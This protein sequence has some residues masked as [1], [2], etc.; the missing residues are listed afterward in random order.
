MRE[1]KAS[2]YAGLPAVKSFDDLADRR[3]YTPLPDDWFVG[4]ADIVGST[5][6]IANGAYKTVNMVGAAV[7]SAQVNAVA[8]APFPFVFGG[9]GAAFANGPENRDGA[10]EALART[11]RWALTE[12]NIDLRAAVV[13]VADIRAAG[14]DVRVAR[15]RTAAGAEYAMFEGGG[16]AWAEERMK[17]G[18]YAVPIAEAG[19]VPNLNGLSCR[20]TPTRA[21]NGTILSVV[22][23][24]AG[25]GATKTFAE[26]IH[27]V[28]ALTGRLDRNGHPL[29]E[30]GAAVHWPPPGL[31]LEAHASHGREPLARRK[32][33]LLWETLIAWL[34]FKTGIKVGGF[35]PA[36]Y[37]RVIDS[38]ADF[39]KFDDGLK[40]TLD[41]DDATRRKL[42]ALLEDAH[43][44]GVAVYGLHAQDQALM[45]CFVPSIHRDD[46]VHFI[47]G[48]DGGYTSAAVAMKARSR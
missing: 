48:A 1:S 28:L 15:H 10:A 40:M 47:D 11:K 13:P 24:P 2:F 18:R 37:K 34:V 4:A 22:I 46:H 33:Q 20:W 30:H 39:R 23:Q 29:P 9:D 45:T 32:R 6:A 14:H 27:R 31:A 36:H 35:D 19:A 25:A 17:A 26:L 3:A 5:E 38:N 7:I 8:G 12:F 21:R 44:R 42:K 43:G 41:C 16:I